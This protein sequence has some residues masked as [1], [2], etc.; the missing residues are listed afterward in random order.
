MLGTHDV[1]TVGL[2]PAA[3]RPIQLSSDT[4]FRSIPHARLREHE[5][6]RMQRGSELTVGVVV[7]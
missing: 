2:W 7:V 4:P 3:S 1:A 5:D 6:L